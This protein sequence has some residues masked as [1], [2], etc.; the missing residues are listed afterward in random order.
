LQG[1]NNM[2]FSEFQEI[3]VARSHALF[4]QCD[5]WDEEDWQCALLG[6]V[7]KLANLIKKI[8]RGDLFD[9]ALAANITMETADCAIYLCL[10]AHFVCRINPNQYPFTESIKEFQDSRRNRPRISPKQR[11]LDIAAGVTHITGQKGMEEG[12][13]YRI[14]WLADIANSFE[15]CLETAMITKH[16]LVCSKM[17]DTRFLIN[18]E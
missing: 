11:I 7:G 1:T 3:S 10:S 18:Q 13:L 9:D 16:N 14:G 17:N 6:E 12:V 2:L 8:R 15:F 4:P 5:E